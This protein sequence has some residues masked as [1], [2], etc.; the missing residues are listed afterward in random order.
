M[1]AGL[2]VYRAVTGTAG[3]LLVPAVRLLAPRG[4]ALRMSLSAPPDPAAAA[5]GSV[6]I[7]AASM[8]EMVA[9]RRWAHAL[10]ASG[11]RTPFYLTART[12]TGLARARS[13]TEGMAVAAIAPLDLPSLVRKTLRA[14]APAR[15]DLVET[16]IWPNL[17][18]EARRAGAP[19]VFVSATVSPATAARLARFGLGGPALL[20]EGVWVLAQSSAAAGRFRGLGVPEGRIAVVGDLKAE[21]PVEKALA[22]PSRRRLVAFGS[23][24]PGEEAAATTAARVLATSNLRL[25]A[26]PRHEAARPA[27][28]AA[29]ERDGFALI[30]RDSAAAAAEPLGAWLERL[31]SSPGG[32]VGILATR[33]EL[34]RAYE[35]AAIAL[36]G[37]SFADYGGHNAIEPAARGC[38]VIVGPRHGEILPAVEALDAWGGV[39]VVRDGGDLAE[40]LTAWIGSPGSRDAA[41]EGASRAAAEASRSAERAIEAL[42]SMGLAA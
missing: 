16:E 18:L 9:A 27:L 12:A 4:G 28:R 22:P 38:P 2:G 20:G 40:A 42:R 23:I 35:E 21:P 19:V 25:L 8:G 31:A 11:H 33:G 37:G 7:H 6:W 15:L 26:A 5:R 30:E 29:L 39:R 24:R 1:G 3:A 41:G 32:T 17:L 14:L 36:A 34:A 13:E 10:A